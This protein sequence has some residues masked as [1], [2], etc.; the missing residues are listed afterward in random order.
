MQQNRAEELASLY[1]SE[2]NENVVPFWLPRAVDEK[3]GGFFTCF[4]H[5]GT[6]YDNTKY[7]WLQGRFVWTL[8]RLYNTVE[9]RPEW[10]E[11][12]GRGLDFIRK[13]CFD[14]N[15]RMY[16]AVTAAGERLTRPWGIFSECFTVCGLCQYALATD[17]EAVA[18]EARDLFW[19]MVELTRIADLDSLSYPEIPR[20]MTHAVPMILV[21]VIQEL[22]AL[23]DD[24]RYTELGDA[25]LDRVLNRHA[26]PEKRVLLENVW[27]DG[28]IDDSPDGRTIN[29]GHALESAWFLLRE[30]EYRNDAAIRDRA[31]EIIEWSFERGWDD[32]YGGLLYFT[33]L[34]SLPSPYLEWDMKL[35]WVQVEALYAALLAH[36][37]TGRQDMLDWF[38]RLHDWS[39][40]RFRDPEHGEWFG[41]LNRDGQVSLSL[42]GSMWKGFYHL[43]RGL[44]LIAEAL[45]QIAAE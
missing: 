33:D 24:P 26:H 20:L 1:R 39:W 12:A 21:N 6:L 19:R 34:K 31:L 15:G 13:R 28:R 18:Q 29:P 10:L 42:K 41:Y 23:G 43:P 35:W 22:R 16:F 30:A 7:V 17:D 5:D 38:E 36:R 4:D 2:L 45:E 44:M 40:D 8:C 14:E 25:M 37:M 32:K 27:P 9:K 3:Q 11:W